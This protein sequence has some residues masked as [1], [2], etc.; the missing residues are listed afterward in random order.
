MDIIKNI[1]ATD[2]DYEEESLRALNRLREKK[3]KKKCKYKDEEYDD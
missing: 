1:I 3:K 2:D